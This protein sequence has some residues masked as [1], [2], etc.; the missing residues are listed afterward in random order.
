M[1]GV[2]LGI[3]LILGGVLAI[4]GFLFP[5]QIRT[6]LLV[7]L[8]ACPAGYMAQLA[9]GVDLNAY[10]PNISLYIGYVSIAAIL[11]WACG[12]TVIYAFHL[13]AA[14]WFRL[15][16]G[17]RLFMASTVPA[18]VIVE[19]VGS[20]VLRMKLRDHTQY[21]SVIPPLQIMH[22]PAWLYLY[23]G[24]IAILFYGLLRGLAVA[25]QEA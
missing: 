8:L 3:L 1:Y 20:H 17:F 21:A 22:A 9:L 10:T 2:E 18:I 19:I 5:R 16:P 25:G 14:R 23:Y 4:C 6:I 24:F 11:T 12:L 13:L 15:R 7:A